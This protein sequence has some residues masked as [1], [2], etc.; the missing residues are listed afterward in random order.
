[1]VF[2]KPGAGCRNFLPVFY[3]SIPGVLFAVSNFVTGNG[4]FFDPLPWPETLTPR[5]FLLR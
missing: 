1:M 3:L 5:G 2:F 4:F